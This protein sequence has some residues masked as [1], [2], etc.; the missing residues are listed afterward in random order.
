MAKILFSGHVHC[1]VHDFGS[2]SFLFILTASR[3]PDDTQIEF[4]G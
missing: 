4:R 3:V 1:K 2:I